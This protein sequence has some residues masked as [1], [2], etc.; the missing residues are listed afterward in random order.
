MRPAFPSLARHARDGLLR[1]VAIGTMVLAAAPAAAQQELVF[2]NG[3]RLLL[4]PQ[5]G[6]GPKKQPGPITPSKP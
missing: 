4:L 5:P 2:D 1:A 3:M 6:S